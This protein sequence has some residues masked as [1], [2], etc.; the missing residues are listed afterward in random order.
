MSIQEFSAEMKF[1]GTPELIEN[2][3]PFLDTSS[4]KHLAE[5]HKLTRQLLENSLSFSAE[6]VDHLVSL[7]SLL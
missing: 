2:L 7:L 6:Q 3:L 1:W 5:S 4:T